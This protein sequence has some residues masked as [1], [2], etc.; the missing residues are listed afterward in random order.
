M[1]IEQPDLVDRAIKNKEFDLLNRDVFV[2]NLIQ[3]LIQKQLSDDGTVIG[4]R[5]TSYVVGLTGDWGTG[6][7]SIL[8]LT[9][10]QLQNEK[11]V[12]PVVFNPWLFSGRD[13]LVAGF[14]G[15]LRETLGRNGQEAARQIRDQLDKYWGAIKFVAKTGALVADLVATGGIASNVASNMDD[16]TLGQS[17]PLSALEEKRS[18]EK[19]IRQSNTAIVVLIDELDR[20]EDDEVRAVAQLLKAIGEIEGISYLVAYDPNR[21]ADALGKGKGVDR[22]ESGE[23]YLEKIIQH[24]IPIRPLFVEDVETLLEHFLNWTEDIPATAN[25]RQNEILEIL[26]ADVRTPREVKRLVGAY[27]IIMKAL[28]GEVCPYDVLAYSW[29]ITR[30]PS[31]QKAI[32]EHIEDLVDDPSQST[33]LNR[34]V[35]TLN[36]SNTPTPDGILGYGALHYDPI[37]R[38]MFPALEGAASIDENDWMRISCRQ[39]L[40]RTLYLGD[41]PSLVSRKVVT[42]V[43]ELPQDA[44]SLKLEELKSNELIFPFLDRLSDVYEELKASE[45]TKFWSSMSNAVRRKTDWIDRPNAERNIVEN[46]A[47]LLLRHGSR[48]GEITERVRNVLNELKAHDDLSILPYVLR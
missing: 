41:P 3:S 39:N 36:N 11:H 6:K 38:K 14:F 21:V 33:M 1:T 37:L 12:I 29:I 48:G 44:L 31:L 19:K 4:C 40:I 25:T 13:E 7:T 43:W 34:A 9:A 15:E 23:R 8:N 24:P 18:L 47:S 16:I 10:A 27:Q 2:E 22:I 20:V 46:A 5:S 30:T 28:R 32:S 26:K 45:D 35:D 17:K 42:Q